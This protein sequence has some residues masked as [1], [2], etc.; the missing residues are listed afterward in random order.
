MKLFDAAWAPS[1]RRVRMYLAEKALNVPRVSVDIRGGA[2]LAADFLDINPRGT[3]PALQL[4]D[5][6]LIL[7]SSAI[8]RFFETLH[9]EP[10]LFGANPRDVARI[11]SV[12]RLVDGEGY[13]AAVYAFRNGHPR[14]A[15]KAL[16][17]CWPEV[18]QI[19]ALV[20]RAGLLWR[21][22]LETLETR[23]AEHEWIAT[24]RLSYADIAAFVTLEFGGVGR[25]DM[26]GAGEGVARWRAAM[27]ARP[28]AAA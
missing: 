5:G 28:S 10:S 24:D 20:A 2:H 15:G 22:F 27:A 21:R 1:P 19:P 13:A 3:L 18:P 11:E 17:G 12:L 7:E 14:L 9:P 4:D 25:L 26:G 6:E 16:P 8:C 23:L